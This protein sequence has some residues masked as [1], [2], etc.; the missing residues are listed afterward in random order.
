MFQ[1]DH[2][3]WDAKAGADT[4][5]VAAEDGAAVDQGVDDAAMRSKELTEAMADVELVG[6]RHVVQ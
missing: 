6:T 2:T 5:S 1:H 4:R 3:N